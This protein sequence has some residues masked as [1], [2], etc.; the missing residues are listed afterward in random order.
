[1]NIY[2]TMSDFLFILIPLF[3]KVKQGGSGRG[4]GPPSSGLLQEGIPALPLRGGRTRGENPLLAL[5]TR[6]RRPP[7]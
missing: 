7:P 6:V 4:G 5:N 3:R 1:M 2:M